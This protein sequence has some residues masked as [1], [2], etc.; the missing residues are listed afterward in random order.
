[1]IGLLTVRKDLSETIKKAV[2]EVAVNLASYPRG[3]QILT[4]F[5]IGGFRYFQPSDLDSV[6]ELI[7]EQNK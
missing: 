7:N 2:L 1:M 3:K 6:L 5:R 4:L